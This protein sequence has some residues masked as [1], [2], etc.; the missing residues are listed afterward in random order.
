[1][2]TIHCILQTRLFDVCASRNF[3]F[4]RSLRGMRTT[5]NFF[6]CRFEVRESGYYEID[7]LQ[8]KRQAL[9]SCKS[10]YGSKNEKNY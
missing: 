7:S 4:T 3:A 8:N 2:R 5:E 9:T 10:F 6:G 1:M